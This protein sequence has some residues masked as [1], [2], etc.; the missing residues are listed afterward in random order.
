MVPLAQAV[1]EWRPHLV[2]HEAAEFAGPI[3]AA[4]IAAMPHPSEV[5]DAL[6]GLVGA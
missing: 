6:E 4:E 5:V 3:A 2:I 1:R